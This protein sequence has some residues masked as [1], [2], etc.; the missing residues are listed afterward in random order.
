MDK[1]TPDDRPASRTVLI[2]L[3]ECNL[4]GSGN[5]FRATIPFRRLIT[6]EDLAQRLA[7]RGCSVRKETLVMAYE[8]MTSEIYNALEDDYNVD[9]GLGKVELN[10]S[11]SFDFNPGIKLPIGE[12]YPLVAGFRPSPRLRQV[13]GHIPVKV[14]DFFP[15]AP[16]PGSVGTV[17]KEQ[18]EVNLFNTLPEGYDRPVFIHGKLMKISGDHP[19]VGITIAHL[20]SGLTYTVPPSMLIINQSTRLCFLPSH[21]FAAGEWEIEIATQ[22]NR[23]YRPYKQPRKGSLTFTVRES[24]IPSVT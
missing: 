6:V 23:S 17:E 24:V 15:N 7:E 20:D 4:P 19:E 14:C 16:R 11:G 13:A 8:M 21:P 3:S 10:V 1:A 2:R 12:R 22:Y 18:T 9:I 5:T